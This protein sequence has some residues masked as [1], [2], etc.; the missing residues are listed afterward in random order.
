[1]IESSTFNYDH[2]ISLAGSDVVKYAEPFVNM[3]REAIPESVYEQL[4]AAL[5]NM[6]ELHTVYALEICMILRPQ[7]FV[8][9]AVEFLLH[10]DAA[11]CCAAY[12]SI[13]NLPSALVT[14][15]LVAKIAATPVVNLY[16]PDLHSD[17]KIPAGTNEAFI[18]KLVSK[19][20]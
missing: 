12:N 6:D 19:F 16:G 11:V 15:D 10:S 17:K 2:F 1:M 14:A 18:R 8:S 3:R 13:N 9:R 7:E 4:E 20:S 5:P